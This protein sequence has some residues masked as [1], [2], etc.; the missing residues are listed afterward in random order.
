MKL[1]RVL[2]NEGRVTIPW[3]IQ[4]DNIDEYGSVSNYLG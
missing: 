2:G 4:F 1:Y 3:D